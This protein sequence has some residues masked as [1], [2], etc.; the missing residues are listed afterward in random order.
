MS[1][2]II[3]TILFL[4]L[5]AFIL[6]TF[7]EIVTRIVGWFQNRREPDSVNLT[8]NQMYVSDKNETEA[9]EFFNV[10]ATEAMRRHYQGG[11]NG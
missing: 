10:A 7:T 5:L 8:L 3:G 4:I 9:Q 2:K 11:G 6:L 1:D